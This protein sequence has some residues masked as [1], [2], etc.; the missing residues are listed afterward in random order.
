M[1]IFERTNLRHLSTLPQL[2]DVATLDLS[3]ISILTVTLR[4]L[5]F[6]AAISHSILCIAKNDFSNVQ[7]MPAVCALMKKNS[8]LITLI[9]PQF[10]AQ[11]SQV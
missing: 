10:E 7:V 3:F 11:R 6:D 2:V 9:K 1:Q 5:S 8:S 4:T